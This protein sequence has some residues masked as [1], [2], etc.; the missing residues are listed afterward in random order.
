MGM[1]FAPSPT[2]IAE[3]RPRHHAGD[4]VLMDDQ[5]VGPVLVEAERRR[6]A[7]G[8]GGE[9]AGDQRRV[10][11]I[12]LERGDESMRT[13]REV[14]PR[15]HRRDAACRQA[16]EQGHALLQRFLEGNLA[17]H[18]LEC[19]LLHLLGDPGQQRQLVDAFLPDHRRIHVGEQQPLATPVG[20]H[21]RHV[22][23]PRR[24][25]PSELLLER[26][27]RLPVEGDLAGFRFGK[28]QRIAETA[29]AQDGER[30][31]VERA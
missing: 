26:R 5:L 20:R 19:H 12:G 18:R 17:P 6:H 8:E 16:L 27:P 2:V 3:D 30:A 13:R 14:E 7:G 9:P 15:R 29:A 23:R 4:H 10:A 31:I 25:R 28:P 24:Q 22:D 1:S 21:Q 11:A